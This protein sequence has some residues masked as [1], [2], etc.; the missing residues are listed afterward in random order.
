M[1]AMPLDVAEHVVAADLAGP[2]PALALPDGAR[3]PVQAP[4]HAEEDQRNPEHEGRRLRRALP[5][6]HDGVPPHDEGDED[7]CDVA[8]EVGSMGGAPAA[9]AD[10]GGQ[11]VVAG[12]R[13]QDQQLQHPE[14][15]LGPVDREVPEVHPQE[16]VAP[17]GH[18]HDV[19]VDAVHVAK[20][21]APKD[22]DVEHDRHPPSSVEPLQRY[23]QHR[24][25]ERVHCDVVDAYVRELVRQAPPHMEPQVAAVRVDLEVRPPRGEV[26]QAPRGRGPGAVGVPHVVV[27]ARP[28]P[29][30]EGDDNLEY[31]EHRG[32][33]L[34]RFFLRRVFR[35]LEQRAQVHHAVAEHRSQQRARLLR[36]HLVRGACVE[37]ISHLPRAQDLVTAARGALRDGAE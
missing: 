27:D 13:R 20:A 36:R 2:A 35:R 37:G 34:R 18:P 32:A 16:G 14:P 12:E 25:Q 15:P 31:D 23:A 29:Q 19:R 22:T 26:V 1:H 7:A 5:A 33:M 4:D 21:G 11:E 17:P 30:P 6:P 24:H 3:R 8:A 10:A 28:E 9:V